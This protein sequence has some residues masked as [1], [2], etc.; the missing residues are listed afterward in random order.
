MAD[1]EAEFNPAEH[2]KPVGVKVE[3]RLQAIEEH[4]GLGAFSKKAKAAAKADA[5]KEEK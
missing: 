2:E 4:L 1:K 3:E 5:D